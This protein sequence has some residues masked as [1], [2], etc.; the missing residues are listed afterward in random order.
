MTKLLS[1]SL[2]YLKS[3]DKYWAIVSS[4]ELFLIEEK[5]FINF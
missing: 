1:S 5:I 4:G 2:K 3:F